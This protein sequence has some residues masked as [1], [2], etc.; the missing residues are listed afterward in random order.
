MTAFFSHCVV[1]QTLPFFPAPLE[2]SALNR[3]LGSSIA[4]CF[5]SVGFHSSWSHRSSPAACAGLTATSFIPLLNPC[6]LV[7]SQFIISRT[8]A[9]KH[10]KELVLTASCSWTQ[11]FSHPLFFQSVEGLSLPSLRIVSSPSSK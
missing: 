7:K 3:H 9:D 10:T 4:S 5:H 6:T 1:D 2:R 8:M 11:L